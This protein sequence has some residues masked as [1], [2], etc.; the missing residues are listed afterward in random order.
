MT[1]FIVHAPL[2]CSCLTVGLPSGPGLALALGPS[3]SGT[4]P[5]PHP[6]AFNHLPDSSSCVSAS[7]FVHVFIGRLK[8]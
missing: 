1:W 7:S 3:H 8:S 6:H 4:F 5:Q 2:L